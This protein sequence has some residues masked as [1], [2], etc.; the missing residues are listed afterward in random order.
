MNLLLSQMQLELLII[1]VE[2]N[3]LFKTLCFQIFYFLLFYILITFFL[4][5][6]GLENYFEGQFYYK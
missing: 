5:Q 3:F 1:I 6:L 4:N 2:F